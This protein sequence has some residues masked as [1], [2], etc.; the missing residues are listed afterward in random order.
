MK[1]RGLKWDDKVTPENSQD[2]L[3]ASAT[4]ETSAE[5]TSRT[6]IDLE[7]A[8][9]IGDTQ[10]DE[11]LSQQS[12][13]TK[14]M[15]GV[16]TESSEIDKS[17]TSSQDSTSLTRTATMESDSDDQEKRLKRKMGDRIPSSSTPAPLEAAEPSKRAR[18]DT[19]EDA[20]PREKKRPSPPPE[21]DTAA[22]KEDTPIPT[23][24]PAA[25][26]PKLVSY[27][28]MYHVSH[29]TNGFI[30][31]G[32]FAAYAST[33]S[34]F[35]AA[36]GP[37]VFGT[38]STPSP[39]PLAGTSNGA[40]SS[41][42]ANLV[43]K[44]SPSPFALAS[45]GRSNTSVFGSSAASSSSGLSTSPTGTKRT[46]FEAFASSSSPFATATRSK[47]PT[48]FSRSNAA[49]GFGLARS[50]SPS[51]RAPGASVNAFKSYVGAGTQSFASPFQPAKKPRQDSSEDSDGTAG[52]TTTS[53]PLNAAS[54]RTSPEGSEEEAEPRPQ[55]SFADRLRAEKNDEETES[56]EE[57]KPSITEQECK[58]TLPT[59]PPYTLLIST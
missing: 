13:D 39:S 5:S 56:S 33:S 45:A 37:S 29:V 19:E 20:N 10:I 54:G 3:M 59:F 30:T 24:E 2:T 17:A 52:V 41:L 48:G 23:P 57:G 9:E 7:D 18:D 26:Q 42:S 16:S 50:K 46:G 55:T 1:V 25:P 36:K 49:S 51:R 38:K 53:N 21:E 40:V 12:T 14:N 31:Q 15:S 11:Q 58:L 32:G 35:A 28:C 43:N 47:S 27:C 4:P 8:A 6:D 22:K 34:P 44:P